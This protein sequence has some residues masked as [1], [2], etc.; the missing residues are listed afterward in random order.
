MIK[1]NNIEQVLVSQIMKNNNNKI[2]LVFN[3]VSYNRTNKFL[4]LPSGSTLPNY[5]LNKHL[6]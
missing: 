3:K 5:T 1:M 4:E 2:V 6:K